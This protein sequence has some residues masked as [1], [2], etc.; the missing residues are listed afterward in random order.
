MRHAR[1]ECKYASGG[2][3]GKSNPKLKKRHLLNGH[4]KSVKVPYVSYSCSCFLLVKSE[5]PSA[6]AIQKCHKLN[7]STQQCRAQQH[8]QVTYL[9][10]ALN[11]SCH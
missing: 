11:A 5:K 6:Q 1:R 2:W 9:P 10:E 8:G 4:K 7:T 3:L